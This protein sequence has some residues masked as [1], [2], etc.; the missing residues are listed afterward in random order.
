MQRCWS[1]SKLEAQ[2]ECFFISV[3]A[4]VLAG[5]PFDVERPGSSDQVYREETEK[6]LEAMVLEPQVNR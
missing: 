3:F 6:R 5:H 1:I 4:L 2:F